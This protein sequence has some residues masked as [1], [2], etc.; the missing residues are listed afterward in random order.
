M[1]DVVNAATRSRMMAGIRSSNTLPERLVRSEMHKRGLRYVLGGAGL[2]GSPDIVLP[3]WRVAV[4]VHGCFWHW[5]GCALS[6]IPATNAGFWQAK[7]ERNADRDT[8]ATM[9]LLSAGWRVAIVWEC[10]LR[11]LRPMQQL[12]DRMDTLVAWTQIPDLGLW[13]EL[14]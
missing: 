11:G 7:L 10:S 12:S 5:H 6:K 9:S 3:R 1:A 8:L 4:F 13:L 14:P 2:P